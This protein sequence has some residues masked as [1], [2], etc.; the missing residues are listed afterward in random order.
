MRTGQHFWNN[1][2]EAL[3][4]GI[5]VIIIL[6]CPDKISLQRPV[7]TVTFFVVSDHDNQP[8]STTVTTLSISLFA[9]L[10]IQ[11][12]HHTHRSLHSRMNR[13]IFETDDAVAIDVV[14]KKTFRSLVELITT[15]LAEY[16]YRLDGAVRSYRG[17]HMMRTIVNCQERLSK[18]ACMTIVL[19]NRS[20]DVNDVDVRHRRK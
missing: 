19:D 6:A 11:C 17:R 16:W 3:E 4:F 1:T 14:A 9:V 12:I 13:K 18:E 5:S 7:L 20:D 15:L 10:L 8:D 2:I